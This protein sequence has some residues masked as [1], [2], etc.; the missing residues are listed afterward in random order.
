M[1]SGIGETSRAL[2]L[3]GQSPRGVARSPDPTLHGRAACELG[4]EVV[5]TDLD[6]ATVWWTS[7]AA[8]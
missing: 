1:F 5:K 2:G 7:L 4:R 8:I 6:R 3:A